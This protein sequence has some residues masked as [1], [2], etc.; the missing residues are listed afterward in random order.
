MAE[1]TQL[2]NGGVGFEHRYGESVDLCLCM[3]WG[4]VMMPPEKQGGTEE[5]GCGGHFYKETAKGDGCLP[6]FRGCSSSTRIE[7]E[8]ETRV[9]GPVYPPGEPASLVKKETLNRKHDLLR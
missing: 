3:N 2:G 5:K 1:V 9:I 6:L 7:Q 8:K 4:W